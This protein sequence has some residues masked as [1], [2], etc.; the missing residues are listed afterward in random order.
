M[1]NEEASIQ[2]EYVLVALV[3]VVFLAAVWRVLAGGY[4]WQLVS[5]TL[6]SQKGWNGEWIWLY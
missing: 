3:G 4:I 6:D 5:A 2:V 1:F